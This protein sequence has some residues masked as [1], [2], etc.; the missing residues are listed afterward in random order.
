MTENDKA[1]L[2]YATYPDADAARAAA[3]YLVEA[4]LAGCVNI[5]PGMTAVYRWSGAVRME[6]E[7]VLIAKTRR[8]LAD[9]LIAEARS[10]H[11]YDTPAFLVIPVVGGSEPY[12]AWLMS[13]L[14]GADD[15]DVR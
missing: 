14:Q 7:C 8:G 4:E 1:V 11:P 5:L 3:T 13:G 2:V 12:I 6:S 9:R 15:G 10:R